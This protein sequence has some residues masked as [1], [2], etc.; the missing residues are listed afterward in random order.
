MK[1]EDSVS[2]QF[3]MDSLP[4]KAGPHG[5]KYVW[6]HHLKRFCSWIGKTPDLLIEERKRDLQSDDP[7]VRHRAEMDV[8]RF[9][10]FLEEQGL[11]D[12]TRRVYF[13]AIRNFY[14][15][16]YYPLEF[17]RGEG[18]GNQTV[19]E[20]RR[21]ASKEDIRKML[22]VSNPRVRALLLF[23]K[24][25][26]LAEADVAK[27]KLKDLG[28]KDVSEI[29]T[30]EPPIPLIVK[31]RKT[32]TLTITFIGKEAWDALKTTLKI[33]QQ[34]SP[35]FQIRRYHKIEKKAGLPPEELKLESPLFR[36]Y[37]KF[38]AR[39]NMPIKHLSPHAISVIVRK[40]AISAGVWKEG[41]SAH[42]LRRFF[43]TSL[44]TSGMNQNWIQRMMGHRLN[45]SEEPYSQPEI[46]M[47]REAYL[48]AYTYL[49]VSEA[50]E[51]RSRVE[52]LEAQV[53]ALMLNGKRKDEEIARL[54]MLQSGLAEK[55][56]A[57]EALLKRVEELE[58]R[59]KS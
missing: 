4:S 33:R 18:P 22:E 25:T 49:A 48:K 8:K 7:R 21:A 51:Q 37:E 32:G 56:V 40:A 36:S 15:R 54:T 44:E 2:V 14:K 5:T 29:F 3:W 34:G 43:Q 13:M 28:V 47:L 50:V 12:N 27:L 39:K 17:F 52:A 6:L 59:L 53:E 58:K 30:L 26:G 42:A 24:D 38:F 35:E 20:G 23:I 31:R 46:E 41:F 57:L 11:S 19:V 55:T 10:K 1:F 9:L 16:N 45:G